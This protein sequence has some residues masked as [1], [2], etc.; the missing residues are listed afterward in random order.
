M[1]TAFWLNVAVPV[2]IRLWKPRY[3]RAMIRDGETL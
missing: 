3:Q 1:I 2:T